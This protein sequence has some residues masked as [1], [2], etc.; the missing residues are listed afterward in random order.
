LQKS[1]SS[2]SQLL[3]VVVYLVVL[4]HNQGRTICDILNILFQASRDRLR[5]RIWYGHAVHDFNIGCISILLYTV[6][7]DCSYWS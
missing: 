6:S 3:V 5:A 4:G 2:T 7:M 1:F